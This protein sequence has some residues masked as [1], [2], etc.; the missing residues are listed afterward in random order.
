FGLNIDNWRNPVSGDVVGNKG[1]T[2]LVGSFFATTPETTVQNIGDIKATFIGTLDKK[3]PF[4][5][6]V[7][8]VH[9][10][11]ATGLLKDNVDG[12][13]GLTIN[14]SEPVVVQHI[15]DSIYI[16]NNT[17]PTDAINVASAALSADGKA[18]T[19]TTAAP[20]A[21]GVDFSIFLNR[22]DYRDTSGNN[23]GAGP[24]TFKDETIAQYDSNNTTTVNT[25]SGNIGTLEL[26]LK[27]YAHPIMQSGQVVS[28][29]QE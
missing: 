6:S 7:S 10:N 24:A 17:K 23:L 8:E 4:V 27:T 5:L 1:A 25:A 22:I 14:F 28:L 9:Q 3:D 11:A 26:K 12:T 2:T 20:I 16:K 18:L 15:N 13:Q 29:Q 19:V 21:E